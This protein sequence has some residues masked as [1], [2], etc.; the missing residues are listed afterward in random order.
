MNIKDTIRKQINQVVRKKY[1]Q[2]DIVF[3]V[4][5]PPKQELGD[6]SCNVAMVLGKK[7][8]RKTFELAQEIAQEFKGS[9]YFSKIDVVAPGFMNFFLKQTVLQDGV[10]EILKQK[11]NFGCLKP[12]KKMKIQVEFISAN[13]TGPLT[14]AN[15]RGG[16]CGDVLVNVL[17]LAGHEAQKE[18]YVNDSGEQVKKLGHSVLRDG[19]TQYSGEYIE[20]LAKENKSK[21]VTTAGAWATQEILEKY[22]KP[23]VK[24]MGIEFDNWFSEKELHEKGKVDEMLNFLKKQ[25]LVFEKDGALWLKTAAGGQTDDKDRVLVKSNKEK[26]YFLAD[27]A[28]HWNKFKIR[29]FDQVINLWGADHHGY[30]PRMQSAMAMLGF[31]NKLDVLLMQL[32]RLIKDGKEYKMSKRQGIYVELVDLIDK[33]GLDVARFFFLMHA[34]NKQ[35][36]F[37]FSL[38]KERSVKNPVF[39]VQYAHAR[40]CSVIKK[41]R[42]QKSKKVDIKKLEIAEKELIKE[43]IKWPELVGEVAKNYEVHKVCFYAISMADKFHNFYEKCQVIENGQVNN[44]RLELIQATKQVLENVLACL[45]VTAPEKM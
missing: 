42:K 18:Y 24:K 15:G 40:I 6:Y 1:Q 34:T 32:V 17:K 8:K 44:F 9:H 25:N 13:P 21:D 19:E 10:R 12:D 5:Y 35:M 38:A 41:A 22:I 43:L 7:L 28:Y 39:Y 11:K 37:D 27:I 16:F 14:L 3:Q 2:Q 33:V 23:A 36:D 45:G 20:K 30:V 26:T 4:E 31:E 29:K